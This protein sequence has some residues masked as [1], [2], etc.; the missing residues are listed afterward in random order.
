MKFKFKQEVKVINNPFYEGHIGVI[1]GYTKKDFSYGS[2]VYNYIYL[3]DFE[4]TKVNLDEEQLELN[5]E[6]V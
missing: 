4:G 3:V 5:N 1:I 6:S 2:Y